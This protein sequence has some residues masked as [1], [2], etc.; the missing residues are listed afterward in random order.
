MTDSSVPAVIETLY[1]ALR[2]YLLS[3]GSETQLTTPG[4]VQEAMGCLKV[5]QGSGPERVSEQDMV[6]LRNRGVS[7]ISRNFKEVLRTHHFPQTWKHAGAISILKQ[8]K[9]PALP[10]SNRPISLLE[11]IVKLFERNPTS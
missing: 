2:P 8:G 10:S 6:C 5:Q 7:L 4:E 3:L 1:V 9:D 11:T